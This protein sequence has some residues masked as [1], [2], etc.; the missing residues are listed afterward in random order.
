MKKLLYISAFLGCMMGCSDD[1]VIPDV[2]PVITYGTYEISCVEIASKTAVT[3]T[4]VLSPYGGTFQYDLSVKREVVQDG[5]ATGTYQYADLNQVSITGADAFTPVLK[6]SSDA[7]GAT[8]ELTAPENGD[9]D[10][11]VY[12]TLKVTVG[13]SSFSFP[14]KQQAGEVR[15][16]TEYFIAHPGMEDPVTYLDVKG[17]TLDY[18][19]GLATEMWINEKLQTPTYWCMEDCDAFS[20]TLSDN[21]WIQIESCEEKLPGI[22]TL[23]IIAKKDPAE[24]THGA[25]LKLKF[26][27]GEFVYVKE[28]ELCSTRIF[29]IIVE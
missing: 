25:K 21:T 24:G 20:Y 13:N 5:V 2:P 18:E 3:D 29:H 27:R 10:H 12:E 9:W 28:I 19:V 11:A 7:K 17:D 15:L 23:R 14:V 1:S 4:I 16:G 22:Y 6:P 26:E 8:L